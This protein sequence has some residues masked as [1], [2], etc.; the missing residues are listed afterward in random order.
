VSASVAAGV[1]GLWPDLRSTNDATAERSE[2][3]RVATAVG[4]YMSGWEVT[5]VRLNYLPHRAL[6][7][8]K[9]SAFDE[10]V[11]AAQD[12]GDHFDGGDLDIVPC[13]L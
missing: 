13:N 10:C 5:H 8:I 9:T 7:R 11:L 2:K 3:V 4:G 1:L 12:Y 6:V